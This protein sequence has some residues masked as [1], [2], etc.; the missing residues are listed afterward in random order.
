MSH[1]SPGMDHAHYAY[2]PLPARKQIA[3]PGGNRIAFAVFLYLEYWELD[4]PK[5]A[6]TD[7]RFKDPVAPF[8]PDYRGYTWREYGN[9]VGI[10]R[11]FELLDRHRLKVTVPVNAMAFERYPYLVDQCL[12]RGWEFAAHGI[13]ANRMISGKMSDDEE[14]AFIAQSIAAIE[15]ATGKRPS[16]WVAQDYGESARTPRL[17]AEAGLDWLCDWPNDD[18]PYLMNAA[19]PIVSLPNQSEWDDVQMLWHRKVPDRRYPEIVTEAF[20]VLA[21]EGGRF[22]GLHLHPWLLGMPHKT[23]YLEQTLATL[24]TRAGAWQATATDIAA[25]ARRALGAS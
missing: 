7:P 12:E 15:T 16:G 17:L 9:R 24:C 8:F 3:W 21:A 11:L 1:R 25:H 18:A 20:D 14:R 22:F 23:V 5:D 2:E 10:F 6:V 13:S 19:R 4:A